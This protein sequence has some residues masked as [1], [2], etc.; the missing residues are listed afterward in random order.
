MKK[1]HIIAVLFFSG[2]WGLAE[3]VLGGWMYA[4]NMHRTPAIIL[5]AVAMGVLVM[6]KRYVPVAGSAVAVAALA[7]LYKFLNQPFFACHLLAIFMLGVG[8][9]AAWTLA[10][11]RHIMLIAPAATYLGFTLF[12]VLSSFVFRNPHW[13]GPGWPK[14]LDYIGITGTIAAACSAVVAP[15]ADRL[16]GVL[17]RRGRHKTAVPTWRILSAVGAAAWVFAIVRLFWLI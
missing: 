13:V 3:A 17:R 2:V 12:A 14:I 11:G 10:R 9:E 6:A 8:F 4:V 5:A 7:M 15:L 16:T 1:Q